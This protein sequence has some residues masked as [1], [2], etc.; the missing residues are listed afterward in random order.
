M[1]SQVSLGQVVWLAQDPYQTKQPQLP[2][3]WMVALAVWLALQFPWVP[4]VSPVLL[5]SESHLASGFL[6]EEWILC[7]QHQLPEPF[8]TLG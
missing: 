2:L 1:G 3:R 7:L 4:P 8:P 6:P 5:V